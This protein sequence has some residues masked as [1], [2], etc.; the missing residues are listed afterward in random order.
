MSCLGRYSEAHYRLEKLFQVL[1]KGGK[2][3]EGGASVGELIQD[4]PIVVYKSLTLLESTSRLSL[5]YS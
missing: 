2:K 4:E 3:D 5:S 1:L